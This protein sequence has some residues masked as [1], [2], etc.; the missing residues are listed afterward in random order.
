MTTYAENLV[1]RYRAAVIPEGFEALL[2]D[3]EL[4]GTYLAVIAVETAMDQG[5]N[6]DNA[7]ENIADTLVEMKRGT[8]R[9]AH[10]AAEAVA[11]HLVHTNNLTS[12]LYA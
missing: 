11:I 1:E 4:L 10:A 5:S 2:A 3:S 9:A 12:E 7:I 8:D 6:V